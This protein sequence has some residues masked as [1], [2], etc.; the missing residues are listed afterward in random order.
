[1]I[2]G[3]V[4]AAAGNGSGFKI[5]EQWYNMA[6]GAI[7][8]PRGSMVS[9][10]AVPQGSGNPVAM[11]LQVTAAAP[12]GGGGGW[13]G[14]GGGGKRTPRDIYGPIVG[15][16]LLIASNL[17]GPGHG[18]QELITLARELNAASEALVNEVVAQKV[19]PQAGPAQAGQMAPIGQAPQQQYQQPAQ[20]PQQAPMQQQPQEIPWG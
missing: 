12:A 1:M 2:Q 17:L 19:A 20:Q 6:E 15:H 18:V 14:K 9:F 13:K 7:A 5:G 4:A 16:N 3:K 11:N 8:P 10:D